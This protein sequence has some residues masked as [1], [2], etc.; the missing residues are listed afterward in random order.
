MKLYGIAETTMLWIDFHHTLSQLK[1]EVT[2][3]FGG[4]LRS[5]ETD[6]KYLQVET[7]LWRCLQKVFISLR[8]FLLQDHHWLHCGHTAGLVCDMCGR[9]KCVITL[10]VTDDSG[11][12]MMEEN[13]F[14]YTL[15]QTG[16]SLCATERAWVL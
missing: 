1:V 10:R 5:D 15:Q 13:L 2:K 11:R 7:M 16:G 14:S 12:H 8:T 6:L 9:W 3:I 4:F